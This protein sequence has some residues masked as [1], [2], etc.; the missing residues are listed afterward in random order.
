MDNSLYLPNQFILIL[1]INK[2]RGANMSREIDNIRSQMRSLYDDG[3]IKCARDFFED[4]DKLAVE[5]GE[6]I[7]R[8][9]R[10]SARVALQRFWERA[11]IVIGPEGEASKVYLKI[12]ALIIRYRS[13][14]YGKRSR[15]P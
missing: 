4:L 7:D 13:Y 6:F 14:T 15:N 5:A 11:G 3:T 12:W 9:D 8:K 1:V 10:N 2:E